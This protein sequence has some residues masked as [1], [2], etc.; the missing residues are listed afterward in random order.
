MDAVSSALWSSHEKGIPVVLHRGARTRL[1]ITHNNLSLSDIT[2]VVRRV[3]AGSGDG[4]RDVLSGCC[5]EG[6]KRAFLLE[7]AESGQGRMGSRFGCTIVARPF[8]IRP[9]D[10]SRLGHDDEQGCHRAAAGLAN[11][12]DGGGSRRRRGTS[13]PGGGELVYF[14]LDTRLVQTHGGH[15]DRVA[16]YVEGGASAEDDVEAR[17]NETNR[18]RRRR[19]VDGAEGGDCTQEGCSL[20]ASTSPPPIGV[21]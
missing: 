12:R 19:M 16:V 8:I 2:R 21:K 10:A 6:D 17:G 15:P 3:A 9:G 13:L 7:D 20:G 11:G 1:L 5:R 14:V 4:L 18:K